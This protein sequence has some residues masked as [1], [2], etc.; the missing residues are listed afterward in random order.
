MRGTP[1][2]PLVPRLHADAPKE[3]ERSVYARSLTAERMGG[4]LALRSHEIARDYTSS[5]TRHAITSSASQL[6]SHVQS[7]IVTTPL[8]VAAL[9]KLQVPEVWRA[10]AEMQAKMATEENG[11]EVLVRELYKR[12][13]SGRVDYPALNSQL[14][15]A[16]PLV[17]PF[18][19]FSITFFPLTLRT[20][21]VLLSVLA[22]LFT[23]IYLL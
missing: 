19:P 10:C 21:F 13:P 18:S 7:N 8:L 23:Y 9:R 5:H 17:L 16:L 22:L 4:W 15:A 11:T 20:A 3:P 1:P 14:P 12:M 2:L 6:G